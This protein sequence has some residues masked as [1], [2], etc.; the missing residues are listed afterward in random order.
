MLRGLVRAPARRAAAGGPRTEGGSSWA[1]R[2]AA[3]P[4]AE[5]AAAVADLVRANVATVLGH[6]DAGS[7]AA[8]RAFK[9]LGFDSLTS[10]ELRNRLS[11]AAGLPLPA[12]LVFDHPTPDAVMAYLE[13]RVR[14][15]R[16]TAPPPDP[17]R[18]APSTT[19]P[20][21]SSP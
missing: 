11:A 12:T 8:E 21:P 16:P 18:P 3:L 14:G 17:A 2:V 20:S 5:R 6:T 4:D 1:E 10:V 9:E 19:T 7:V 15:D 13:E